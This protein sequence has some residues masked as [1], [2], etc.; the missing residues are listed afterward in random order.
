LLIL[1]SKSPRR[2]EILQSAGIEFEVRVVDVPEIRRS[3]EAPVEY[4]RRLAKQKAAAVQRNDSETVLGADTIVLVVNEVFE[5]PRDTDDAKRMLRRLSGREHQVT[6][7]IC[8]I[9]PKGEVVDSETTSV[10]FTPLT[11][12]EIDAYIASGEPMDKAGAYAI[13][14][15]ASKFIDRVDGDYF[16]VMGLPVARVYKH[17]KVLSRG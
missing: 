13:Q 8:L 6:T 16:N 3:G 12:A 14:G 1:A 2:R 4:V 15:L 17:M 5:K 7:G 9:A 11:D 10:R